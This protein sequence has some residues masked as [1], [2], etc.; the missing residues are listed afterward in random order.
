MPASLPASRSQPRLPKDLSEIISG[1]AGLGVC[2]RSCAGTP[3][4]IW[5][6]VAIFFLLSFSVL[7][8]Y[9][10]N[11]YGENGRFFFFFK[12]L[13]HILKPN[14][15]DPPS[16]NIQPKTP[17]S[18]E[19]ASPTRRS[20]GQPPPPASLLNLP[21]NSPPFRGRQSPGVKNWTKISIDKVSRAPSLAEKGIAI[22]K[23]SRAGLFGSYLLFLL[24]L[25][26]ES[27]DWDLGVFVSG[28][29]WWRCWAMI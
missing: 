4:A 11:L 25:A 5:G 3:G 10:D 13:D 24:L 23:R 1:L 21:T 9:P 6:Y 27:K 2:G 7:I 19:S 28:L 29:S 20:R 22:R 16:E 18:P 8:Y 15:K 14:D 17:N 12:N 26:R